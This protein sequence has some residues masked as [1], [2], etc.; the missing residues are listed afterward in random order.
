MLGING[1]TGSPDDA[2]TLNTY[3][4]WSYGQDVIN[5][6]IHEISEGGMGRIGGLGGSGAGDWAPMDLFRYNASGNPDYTNGRDGDTT[7]FSSNGG[8]T[9]SNEGLPGKGA[10][11]LSYHNQYDPSDNFYS[12]DNDDW[13]QEAVFGT[14]GT[15]ETLTLTQTELDV[16]QA[17]G[18]HL[19]LKQD[20]DGTSGSWETP[21]DWS[22]G[23]MPI[24]AQDA[25][26]NGGATVKLDSNVIVHSIATTGGSDLV[27]GDTA[28][29]T[30][31]AVY[32]TDLN[33]EDTGST[34]SGNSG[35]IQVDTGSALQIGFF[36]DYFDNA[37]ILGV[38]KGAGGSGS[39]NIAADITLDGGGDVF[40]GESGTE[41]EIRNA[42]NG[43]G[44]VVN[45]YLYNVDNTI[46]VES[47]STGL[48]DLDLGFDNQSGGNVETGGFLQISVTSSF[49]NEGAMT[50]ELGGTL[51]LGNGT[52]GS[53]ANTGYIYVDS[54]GYLTISDNFTVSGGAIVI[55]AGGTEYIDSGGTAYDTDIY[56]VGYTFAG[57]VNSST[58]I[59]SGGA[60]YIYGH[61]YYGFIGTGGNQYVESGGYAQDAT[62][63]AG[64]QNVESG[65]EAYVTYD[66][67]GQ[68]VYSGGVRLLYIRRVWRLPGNPQRRD[69]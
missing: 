35:E 13:S 4:G 69:R 14:V 28:A 61:S 21:T 57:G 3:Y 24:E 47:G 38:G 10:P 1:Y 30:L 55:S 22:T 5:G 60:Q 42:P 2:V 17:L 6:V 58:Y 7:Y 39:L 25:L 12:G 44:G 16:M 64:Y 51:Y 27:I 31:T 34:T 9:L 15:G 20:V 49:T 62:T 26:I 43:S 40:L 50:A 23:S 59:G 11:T 52:A 63:D 53:L 68:Y 56:G 29:T 65:G 48:I 8:S 41:G 36:D 67:G 18:W 33:S 45:G 19:S 37:G 66:Y 32:G 46:F 54:G